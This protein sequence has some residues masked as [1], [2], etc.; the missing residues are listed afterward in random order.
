MRKMPDGN[1]Q[2]PLTSPGHWFTQQ[3]MKTRGLHGYCAVLVLALALVATTAGSAPCRGLEGQAWKE[4]LAGID[5]DLDRRAAEVEAV[6]AELPGLSTEAQAVLASADNRHT[7]ALI[8]RAV[9]GDTPWALRSLL[10]LYTGLDRFLERRTMQLRLVET[11]LERIKQESAVLS[12]I[13][14]RG[15]NNDYNDAT[16]AALAE[17]TRKMDAIRAQV[18]VL[19]TQA[20]GILAQFK[21]LEQTADGSREALKHDYIKVFKAHFFAPSHPFLDGYGLV[22][23]ESKTRDWLNDFPMF[24]VPV[25]AGTNWA[26]LAGVAIPLWLALW[27]VGRW[28]GRWSGSRNTTRGGASSRLGWALLS[29]GVVVMYVDS[30]V[31][32]FTSNHMLNLMLVVVAAW[33]AVILTRGRLAPGALDFFLKLFVAGSLAQMMDLPAELVCLAWTPVMA[34]A[35]WNRRR[36]GRRAEAAGLALL[37]A[38]CLAGFGPQALM[39]AQA[40]FLLLLAVASARSIA[41]AL[42]G[43]GG[44]WPGYLRPLAAILIG[45]GYLAW[46]FLFMGG[47]G[48]LDYVFSL[49]LVFGPVKLSLDAAASMAVLFFS[50]RLALAWLAAFLGRAVIDGNPLDQALSHTL[51]TLTSYVVWVAY[52]LAALHIL[53]LPLSGLTWVASGLSVGVGF[54]LKD[55]INNFVSG[56]II[57]FGGSIKKGDVVQTGKTLGEVTAV[58]VRNTTVRTMDNSTV[59]IPN[60]SFLKGEIVNWSYQDRRIRLTV[61]VSV[62]PGSKIK[63][64]R[65]VL[66]EAARSHEAVLKEPAPS[67]LLRQLGK[68]GLDFELYVWI[69]DFR[70]KFQVQSDLASALDQALQE[71]SITVAFQGAKVKYKPMGSEAAQLEAAREALKEKRRQVFALV[72]PL[73][74]VHA[75][76]RWGV[77]SQIPARDED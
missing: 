31:L 60:S 40:W 2:E 10:S 4:V 67:V 35:A 3:F 42:D 21:S 53:G 58:S 12:E 33:G 38:V 52:L 50:V 63:K 75:R 54:G 61:P 46:L 72:R 32:A 59:I 29:F 49:K 22:L 16:V 6:R 37:G 73:R 5:R 11:R 71:N 43:I 39:A 47:P 14:S 19:K 27:F 65:K 48:F 8:L 15:P 55:I 30:D 28:A 57:L 18:D 68:M 20:D 62:V 41:A 25:L 66:L 45:V 9:A 76:A 77:P 7:Q 17:P 26:L 23:L 24:A 13:R 1:W 70:D 74:R 44:V 56:L 64:V 69:E 36:R 34:L 51:S